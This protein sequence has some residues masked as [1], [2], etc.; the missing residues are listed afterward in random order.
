MASGDGTPLI[1][2][3]ANGRGGLPTAL[4]THPGGGSCEVVVAGAHVTSWKTPDGV[5]RLFVSSASGFG[6]GKAIRGGIPVCFPQFA[7][8]GPLPKHGFART[9]AEWELESMSSEGGTPKLVLSLSDSEATRAVWPHAFKLVYSI[10]LTADGLTTEV[11]FANTGD[12]PLTF[13]GALHTYFATPDVQATRVRGLRGITY[14]DNTAGCAT[15]VEQQE[16]VTLPGEVD[17]VYL[18]A[19]DAVSIDADGYGTISLT[20]AG[21]PDV[22]LW[23]LG[24]AKAPSMADL[25]AG[26]WRGYVCLE[27][28]AIGKPVTLGAGEAFEA[29][30][31]FGFEPS[32]GAP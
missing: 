7:G 13:T 5:E 21:F 30:Q 27:A 18:D 17:R 25:G 1:N 26:E 15:A 23:N 4:L 29:S 32:C 20:K 2:I 14:E 12:T 10:T 31:T 19:P 9:S 3:N 28:G 22:V 11:S 24:E 8:R 16:E 6:P